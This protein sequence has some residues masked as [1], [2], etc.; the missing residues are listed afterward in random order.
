MLEAFKK[1]VTFTMLTLI[2]NVMENTELFKE[3]MNMSNIIQIDT[4]KYIEGY[5][6]EDAFLEKL[7]NDAID[8]LAY[9]VLISLLDVIGK[10]EKYYLSDIGWAEKHRTH[11][12]MTWLKVLA[13]NLILSYQMDEFDTFYVKNK[14]A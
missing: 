14:F 13:N 11:I 8:G 4:D 12:N 7:E 1:L 3:V 5:E 6:H 10:M 2:S 9:E